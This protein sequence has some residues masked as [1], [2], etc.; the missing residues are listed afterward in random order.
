MASA[1]DIAN[2]GPIT[3]ALI[4]ATIMTTLDS[5]IANVALPHM[6]G[7]LSAAPDQ[8]AWV[9]TSYL[10]AS[11]ILTPLT[12][13]LVNR[14]GMKRL[15]LISVGGFTLVSMLCGL[16]TGLG[17]IVVFRFLQG[18]FG[19]TLLPLS[20]VA[21]LDLY[22]PHQIGQV[23]ALWG[24]ATVLGPIFGPSLGGWL[25]DNFSW[26][27]VFYINLPI[28]GLALA[29]AAY[30]M[31]TVGGTKG[32]PFDFLGFGA[33]TVFVGSLQM[34]LDRGPSQDWYASSE[35]WSE[36]I[37]GAIG[38]WVFL[39][40]TLTARNPF[41]PRA[42]A[43]DR[44]F[45]TCAMF[46]FLSGVLLFS[47]MVLLPP[48]MQQ[49]MGY[50]AFESGLVSVPRGLGTFISMMI[51][52]RLIGRVDIRLI[53][54]V[55]FCLSALALWQMTRFDLSMSSGPIMVSGVIQGFGA[56]F[57]F[58]PLSAMAFTT[59][60][61]PMRP[62]AT[63]M[64]NVMRSLGFSIGISVVQAL[65]TRNAAVAHSDMTAHVFSGDPQLR[66]VMPG[67]A[68]LFSNEGLQALNGEISR[69][70]AMV[71]YID[72]F[73]VLLILTFLAMPFLLFLRAPKRA[74]EIAHVAYE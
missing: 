42:L 47:T 59:L 9:L 66:G 13:W 27:W 73:R 39:A 63:A 26:R 56:G 31:Q 60:P 15:F 41:F 43:M 6:Q 57:I 1:S 50:S 24:G 74:E 28:G 68:N 8:I 67:L 21:I 58:V 34:V 49:L 19:A 37:I 52:G 23:M 5:T 53:L 17:E 65:W 71:S 61:Q 7:S 25:T 18:A 3:V 14:I 44:N 46:A 69:Q 16:A 12:G 64:Y 72:A 48:M 70:A 10:I 54:F 11:A 2:R 4:T 40:Q 45:V 35:I 38:F 51:V 29:G 32:R 33:L 55:G 62:D 22:P 36:T 30:F 20:Q